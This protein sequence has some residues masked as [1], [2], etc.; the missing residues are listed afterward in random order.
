MFDL[1]VCVEP[2]FDNLPLD[3]RVKEVNQR[4]FLAEFWQWENY[5]AETID[6]IAADPDSRISNF[7]GSI[8]GSMVHP[9]GAEAYVDGVERSAAVAKKLRCEKLSIT[10]GY[11]GPKGEVIH[12]IAEHPATLWITAYKTLCKVAEIAERFNL[13]I[14]LESL[15]TKVDHAGYPLP[16]V[17]DAARLVEAVGSP[18]V[19][20]LFDIYHVQ[21]EEG[22]VIQTLRDYSDFIAHV[23]VADVPGRHEPGTGEINYPRVVQALRDIN[24]EGTVGLEAWPES[25]DLQ[26]LERFR[27]AFG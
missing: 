25:D 18:R 5:P 13:I 11:H 8:A 3:Q 17:Q 2:I 4:G 27:K 1:S 23:H 21:V 14:C 7:G 19:K 9:D 6:A 16:R 22:N 24:Y 15:N 26:A 20:I 12:P 10:T